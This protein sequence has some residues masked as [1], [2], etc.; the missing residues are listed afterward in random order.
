MS[1]PLA[2]GSANTRLLTSEAIS[3]IQSV[4]FWHGFAADRGLQVV[5]PSTHCYLD[6][7]PGSV[8]GVDRVDTAAL[9]TLRGLVEDQDSVESGWDDGPMTTFGRYNGG[10]LVAA[11][12][13]ND[14]DGQPRDIGV[15]VAP[16][17]RG[18]GLSTEVGRHAASHAIRENGFARWGTRNDNKASLGAARR[19]GFEEWCTQL[20][21]R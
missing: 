13:L 4:D 14:F 5:G 17:W 1:V 3:V 15:L 11:S 18:R 8:A 19:L 12:N 10:T 16:A 9:A 2:A 6:A 21:V 7:D 20:W